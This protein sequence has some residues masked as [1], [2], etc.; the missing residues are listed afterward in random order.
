MRRTHNRYLGPLLAGI[1]LLLGPS[2]ALAGQIIIDS[3]EQFELGRTCMEKGQYSRAIVEF[4]RFIH[5]FPDSPR[6]LMARYLIGICYLK[7]DRYEAAREGFFQIIRSEPD[8]PLAGKALFMVGE[9]YYQQGAPKEAEYY[10]RQLT[11]KYPTPELRNQALYRIGW[12]RMKEDRW[13]DASAFFMKVERGSPL[14]GSSQELAVQSLKGATL[15][16]KDPA[17][18][19]VMAG[20]IPGMGHAYVSRYKDAAVAFLLNGLFVWAAVE[21]FN[22][23][24]NVLGGILSF[25]ELG[26]YTGNIYSAVNVAHKYNLKVRNDFRKG[27]KDCLGLHLLTSKRGAIGLAMT[28]QF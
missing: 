4:E 1:I 23:N 5:F 7:S 11:E 20:I 24:N 9:S 10:F 22:N 16:Y 15:P 28:F 18:A 3:G 17:Y 19:G 14:Y 13:G 25:F 2:P 12:A 26:W 8:T 27:L 21:A 6:V